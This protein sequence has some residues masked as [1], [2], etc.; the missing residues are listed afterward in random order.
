MC[1]AFQK[2]VKLCLSLCGELDSS[3]ALRSKQHALFDDL[4][5]L[6][7]ISPLKKATSYTSKSKTSINA[8]FLWDLIKFY[9]EQQ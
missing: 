8:V 9:K 1:G 4:K 2:A 6:G 7:F 3:E 5:H